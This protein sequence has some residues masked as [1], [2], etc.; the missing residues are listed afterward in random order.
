M[1]QESLVDY[2]VG[3][4]VAAARVRSGLEIEALAAAVGFSSKLLADCERGVARFPALCLMRV[5]HTLDVPFVQFFDES[6]RELRGSVLTRPL[7][8]VAGRNET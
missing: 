4:R 2:N 5:A 6:L 7:G 1:A 3:Q 8:S